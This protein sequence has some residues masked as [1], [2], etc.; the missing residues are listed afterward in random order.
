MAQRSTAGR[1][2]LDARLRSDLIPVCN[3]VAV[4]R[5]TLDSVVP[6]DH[7]SW[8]RIAELRGIARLD[9]MPVEYRQHGGQ[10]RRNRRQWERA[11]PVLED[12]ARGHRYRRSAWFNRK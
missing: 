9:E 10:F 1:A 6:S 2:R 12:A 8:L 4:R 11:K 5:E 7:D 3:A